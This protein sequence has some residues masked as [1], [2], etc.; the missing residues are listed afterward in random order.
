MFIIQSNIFSCVAEP[1]F[2]IPPG[3]EFGSV[4]NGKNSET[5]LSLKILK[6]DSV[7][8][9]SPLVFFHD[10]NPSD[11]LDPSFTCLRIF[12]HGDFPKENVLCCV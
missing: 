9:F 8:K 3:A 12:E 7:T 2:F 11:D 5:S 6:R 1:G 10:F 4:F